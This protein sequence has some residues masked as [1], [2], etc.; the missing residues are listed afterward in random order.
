MQN[1]YFPN[2][3]NNHHN[4]WYSDVILIFYFTVDSWQQTYESHATFDNG[5]KELYASAREL[6]FIPCLERWQT[7]SCTIS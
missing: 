1:R 2:F 4:K 6:S 5:R 7:T 3:L